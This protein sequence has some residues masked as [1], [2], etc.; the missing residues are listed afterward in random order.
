MP[1]EE[2]V[3]ERLGQVRC[4]T[5]RGHQEA[6]HKGI[7]RGAVNRAHHEGSHG[8]GCIGVHAV[9]GADGC[10]VPHHGGA[11]AH[12]GKVDRW[13]HAREFTVNED[14]SAG[15]GGQAERPVE[16]VA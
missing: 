12:R 2:P 8:G 6:G 15:S 3:V 4:R 13:R 10:F 16:G 11:G 7:G 1:S 14:G 9:E 5:E